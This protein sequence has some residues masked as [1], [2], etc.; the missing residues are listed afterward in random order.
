MKL[1]HVSI[2][3]LKENLAHIFA[4]HLDPLQHRAF[5]FGSRVV[6]TSGERSD[7]DLGIDRREPL[8]P[9]TKVAI[10]DEIER[11]PI[12]YTIDLVDFATVRP[13]FRKSALKH[14]EAILWKKN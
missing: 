1:E 7:I 12:L 3:E 2:G 6:G 11:L 10:Q 4:A 8:S 5:F 14:A 13:E 9:A